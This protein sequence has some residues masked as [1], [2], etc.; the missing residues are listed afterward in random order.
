[1]IPGI[2]LSASPMSPGNYRKACAFSAANSAEGVEP[3]VETQR[4]TLKREPR[5]PLYRALMKA[6]VWRR[7]RLASQFSA[8]PTVAESTGYVALIVAECQRRVFSH[9]PILSETEQTSGPWFDDRTCSAV[10]VLAI[11]RGWLDG[12]CRRR[13]S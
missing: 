11:V 3:A 8:F 6:V 1:M 5:L 2:S 9:H 13:R 10:I 7:Q 4:G 12:G